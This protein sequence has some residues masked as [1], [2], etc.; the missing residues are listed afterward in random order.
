M[1]GSASAPLTWLSNQSLTTGV[2]LSDQVYGELRR[3]IVTGALVPNTPI[4][5]P[6]IATHFG[7]SRTPVRE[8]LLRLRDDGLVIIR[9]QA[10][11]FVAP[12]DPKRVEEGMLVRE[13]LEPRIVEVA[14]DQLSEQQLADLAAETSSMADAIVSKD[15]HR[16]IEADDRFHRILIDACRF[17]HI[18]DIIHRVNAQLD[19]VRYLGASEPVRARTAV[20]EHR[21]LIDCLRKKDPAGSADLLRRHLEQAWV[22]IRKI[23][24]DVQS[25]Q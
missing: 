2:P 12:I 11:T 19:R 16:F 17:D 21:A 1:D 23:L 7:V 25:R 5:E 13:S 4:Q 8:A 3:A 24:A 10:G 18:A 22:Q 15:R 6:A 9:K 20:R 14:T